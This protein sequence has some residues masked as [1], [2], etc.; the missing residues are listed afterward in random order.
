MRAKPTNRKKH[1][2][3]TA[4]EES[5]GRDQVCEGDVH[6]YRVVQLVEWWVGV[7]GEDCGVEQ[8]PDSERELGY[9]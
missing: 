4:R 5:T 6:R 3:Q 2:R 9:S 8:L 7:G 1:V